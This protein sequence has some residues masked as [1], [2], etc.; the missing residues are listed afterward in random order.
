MNLPHVNESQPFPPEPG[1]DFMVDEP[2]QAPGEFPDPDAYLFVRPG[3]PADP[4]G[5][6]SPPPEPLPLPDPGPE[7]ARPDPRFGPIWP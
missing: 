5:M 6:P 1:P 7:L 4:G 3:S 2:G